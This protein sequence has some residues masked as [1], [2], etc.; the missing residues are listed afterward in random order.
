[1]KWFSRRKRKKENLDK[2]LTEKFCLR[3]GMLAVEM[4]FVTPNQIKSAL[5]EQVD[6]EISG[7]PH[8]V[9][10]KILFEHGWMQPEQIDQVM[11]RLYK[12]EKAQKQ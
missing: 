8:R 11:S 12:E 5:A 10:G 6:D 2:E 4:G 7:R 9:I 1:M 3:F